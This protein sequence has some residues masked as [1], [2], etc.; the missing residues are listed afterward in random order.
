MDDL[1]NDPRIDELD[2]RLLRLLDEH[3][4]ISVLELSRQLRVARGTAQARLDK[5]RRTGIVRSLGPELEPAAL[6][7]EVLAFVTIETDQSAI[8]PLA[9]HFASIPEVIEAH[10]TS[11]TGDVLVKVAGRSNVDLQR[12][13]TRLL[14]HSAV[15]RTDTT[16]V[17]STLFA[18]RTLP[19]A[20][21]NL[22]GR[23]T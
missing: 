1:G 9:E 10:T 14:D 8:G 12:V 5:L 21:A 23:R 15:L 17:L 18:P 4:R 22:D 13:L 6:G 3:P 11:G 7:Y 19:L 2:L 16:I 20:E